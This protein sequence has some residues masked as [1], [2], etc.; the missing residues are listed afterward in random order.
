MTFKELEE[1]LNE[2]GLNLKSFAEAIGLKVRS[3]RANY[4]N[5]SKCLPK[6]YTSLLN[7]Y[8]KFQKEKEKNALLEEKLSSGDSTNCDELINEKAKKIAHKKC[9]ENS[10]TINEYLSSLVISNL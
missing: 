1:S 9:I 4:N 5:D 6:H 7:L 3:I 10:I 2:H 8:I